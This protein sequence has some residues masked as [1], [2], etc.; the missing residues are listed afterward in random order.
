[1]VKGVLS[2]GNINPGRGDS[3][4]A[5]LTSVDDRVV[6]DGVL[7]GSLKFRNCRRFLTKFD[8]IFRRNRS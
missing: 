1:M 8:E 7:R 5:I 6:S 3:F 4:G 2:W